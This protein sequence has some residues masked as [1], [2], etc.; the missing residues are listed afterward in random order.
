[1][2]AA[3][4]NPFVSSVCAQVTSFLV[5]MLQRLTLKLEKK[6]EANVSV[7][8]LCQT[9]SFLITQHKFKGKDRQIKKWREQWKIDD[10]LRDAARA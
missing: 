6:C 10:A 7:E 9:I 1:M 5:T 8:S 4:A 2:Y 3:A